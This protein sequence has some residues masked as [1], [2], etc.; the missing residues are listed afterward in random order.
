MN[1][2]KP[3]TKVSLSLLFIF[4]SVVTGHST[5]AK[6]PN[7][8]SR[9][10]SGTHRTWYPGWKLPEKNRGIIVFRVQAKDN[11]HVAF[12]SKQNP[13]TG[14]WNYKVHIGGWSNTQTVLDKKNQSTVFKIAHKIKPDDWY[15]IKIN[16]GTF[17]IG[18]GKKVGENLLVDK[19]NQQKTF[20]WTDNAPLDILYFSFSSYKSYV[21]Y[22]DIEILPVVDAPVDNKTTLTLS[23]SKS[24]VYTWKSEWKLPAQNKGIVTFTANAINDIFIGL[25]SEAP[26]TSGSFVYE[27]NVGGWKN[28]RTVIRKNSNDAVIASFDTTKI[29]NPG[30]PSSYWF[31]FDNGRMMLGKGTKPGKGILLDWTDS[32]PSPVQYVSFANLNTPITFSNI[33]IKPLED[34][35]HNQLAPQYIATGHKEGVFTTWKQEW[36]LP[37]PDSGTVTFNALAPNSLYIALHTSPITSETTRP[38]Y[39]LVIDNQSHQTTLVTDNGVQAILYSKQ[40]ITDGATAQPYWFSYNKG[41]LTFGKGNSGSNK[42]FEYTIQNPRTNLSYISFSNAAVPVIYTKITMQNAA[43]SSPKTYTTPPNGNGLATFWRAEWKFEHAITF[44]VKAQNGVVVTLGPSY[45]PGSQNNAYRVLINSENYSSIVEGTND[46]K[47]KD[48]SANPRAL[49]PNDGAKHTYWVQK[50]GNSLSFGSGSQPGNNTLMSW[51]DSTD[52]IATNYF[53]FASYEK[54]AEIT[55]IK[56][57]QPGVVAQQS[58]TTRAANTI[59][60]TPAQIK[61][62]RRTV[63]R[64]Y[65]PRRR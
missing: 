19:N 47:L 57:T 3:Y 51:E 32:S 25:G 17:Q 27:L 6:P 26:K 30:T 31:L 62:T 20:S 2:R 23:N 18:Q 45:Q 9:A 55:N 36:K 52:P 53:S 49:L 59:R 44:D 28:T 38:N 37:T 63:V 13:P 29:A 42:I 12:H 11:V 54:S 39:Y 60:T 33:A 4:A 5:P 14:Q 58:A 61:T 24:G 34:T 21:K 65:S 46:Q 48:V 35:L 56:Q 15:W 43:T 7:Y 8:T 22:S 50:I 1:R 64:N 10:E 40:I 16:N 41:A